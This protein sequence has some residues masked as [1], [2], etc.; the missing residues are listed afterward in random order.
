MRLNLDE[1]AMLSLESDNKQVKNE[2]NLWLNMALL[3]H[4]NCIL[5]IK[6]PEA[7]TLMVTSTQTQGSTM[8]APYFI[9]ENLKCTLVYICFVIFRLIIGC[10]ITL[11]YF[12][13]D[14]S[15]TLLFAIILLFP[16]LA[17]NLQLVSKYS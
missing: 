12:G 5:N 8:H 4:L 15:G 9:L 3:M 13:H 14:Q 1:W 11:L 7:K 2:N 17:L 10:G 6:S 16:N